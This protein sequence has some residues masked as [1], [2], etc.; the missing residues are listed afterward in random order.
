M[1]PH[2]AVPSA[3]ALLGVPRGSS[4]AQIKRAFHKLALLTHPDKNDSA[5][6]NE[7][8]QAL[9]EAYATASRALNSPHGGGDADLWEGGGFQSRPTATAPKKVWNCTV[10]GFRSNPPGTKDC[11][12]CSQACTRPC[13]VCGK[14]NPEQIC[15]NCDIKGQDSPAKTA[16]AR[17]A[18]PAPSPGRTA[19]AEFAG[20]AG[21]SSGRYGKGAPRQPASA[22]ASGGGGASS[23]SGGSRYQGAP[24]APQEAWRCLMCGF[25]HNPSHVVACERCTTERPQDAPDPRRSAPAHQAGWNS[26]RMASASASASGGGRPRP[27]ARAAEVI[28][29]SDS[30]DSAGSA[31][32][33]PSAPPAEPTSA[34]KARKRARGGGSGKAAAIDLTL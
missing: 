20:S 8:F 5:R 9:T 33:A 32:P 13:M 23:S 22:S 29:L 11:T 14:P 31:S 3:Y 15:A 16:Q 1:E 34:R 26:S 24:A 10:C 18:G 6:A 7:E 19:S 28:V 30:D 21:S 25:P 4:A 27:R 17:H 2:N 12:R